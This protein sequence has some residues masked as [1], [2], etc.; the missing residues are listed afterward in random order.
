MTRA[1]RGSGVGPDS[2][3]Q[4][5]QLDSDME[6]SSRV[7]KSPTCHQRNG[8]CALRSSD[9]GLSKTGA[10]RVRDGWEVDGRRRQMRIDMYTVLP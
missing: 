5:S 10:V 4:S 7:G 6:C 9:L 1:T 3:S 2:A 8:V